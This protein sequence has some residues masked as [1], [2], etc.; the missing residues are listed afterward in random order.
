MSRTTDIHFVQLCFQFHALMQ[1]LPTMRNLIAV[2]Y[3]CPSD[4]ICWCECH[5]T[6]GGFE[7]CARMI[8]VATRVNEE[9]KV[10][11]K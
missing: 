10:D 11:P 5:R 6:L 9:Q 7:W 1:G 3:E 8:A 4:G 2:S